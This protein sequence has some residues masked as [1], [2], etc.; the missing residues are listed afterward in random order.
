[1]GG[2]SGGYTTI[3]AR[4]ETELEID[5]SRFICVLERVDSEA[6]ARAAIARVRAAHPRARHHCT[7]FLIGP[8]GELARSNDDGE[9]SGTAG[10]PMLEA[11]RG[12]GLSDVVAIVTRYFGG[13]LLGTGG[14]V[15]AYSASVQESAAAA[16]RVGRSL[17]VAVSVDVDYDLGPGLEAE[18]RRLGHPPVHVEYGTGMRI[19]LA[20]APDRV[21]DL[22]ARVAALTSGRA[23][24][25]QTG[26]AWADDP[27]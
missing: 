12:A 8:R 4:V 24:T 9:P 17:R 13:V 18:L 1:M 26:S 15:R 20:A 23:R 27:A 25:Q 16:A 21:D 6:A 14:L 22:V 7:A 5:R 2:A 3:A 11:L 10:L 19:D